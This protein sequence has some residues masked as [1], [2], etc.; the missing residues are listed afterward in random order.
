VKPSPSRRPLRTSKPEEGE[1]VGDVEGDE[2]G[3]MAVLIRVVR[4]RRVGI[5]KV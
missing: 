4:L 2:E 5:V 3:D 1:E